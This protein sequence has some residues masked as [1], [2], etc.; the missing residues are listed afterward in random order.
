MLP[1]FDKLTVETRE[2]LKKLLKILLVSL[3]AAIILGIGYYFLSVEVNRL[4]TVN[5]EYLSTISQLKTLTSS[6]ESSK[7]II[8]SSAGIGSDFM[9]KEEFISFVGTVSKSEGCDIMR[10]SGGNPEMDGLVTKMNFS[11]EIKGQSKELLNFMRRLQGLNASYILNSVSMRKIED[12]EWLDRED[13]DSFNLS[14]W[15]LES[16]L[17]DDSTDDESEY[18][19][20]DEIFGTDEMTLYLDL[21]FVT[22][23]ENS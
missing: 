7:E 13:L 18:V 8:E 3:A 22:A 14:W 21:D 2:Q 16:E 12:F 23:E 20:L 19:T 6:V 1:K 9:T 15:T 5:S 10:I 11:F 4:E 17:P